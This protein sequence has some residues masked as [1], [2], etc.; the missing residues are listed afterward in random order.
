MVESL[1][2]TQALY[3]GVIPLF[4][5]ML[6]AYDEKKVEASVPQKPPEVDVALQTKKPLRSGMDLPCDS[7]RSSALMVGPA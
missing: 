4:G 7:R 2:L 3:V 1:F 5:L 6:S